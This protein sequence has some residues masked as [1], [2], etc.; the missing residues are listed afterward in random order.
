[1]IPVR[2]GWL[3]ALY[4]EAYFM[5]REGI[6]QKG[7]NPQY[8]HAVDVLASQDPLVAHHELFHINGNALFDFKSPKFGQYLTDCAGMVPGSFDFSL[9]KYRHQLASAPFQ[10]V[11][12]SSLPRF[13]YTEMIMNNPT[14]LCTPTLGIF[15]EKHP[16]VVVVHGKAARAIRLGTTC[17]NLVQEDPEV[18]QNA[19]SDQYHCLLQNMSHVIQSMMQSEESLNHLS[20]HALDQIALGSQIAG[21]NPELLCFKDANCCFGG[22]IAHV[23]ESHMWDKST[24]DWVPAWRGQGRPACTLDSC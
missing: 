24:R 13:Q 17:C 1:M 6:W 21:V 8:A 10:E 15:L 5:S 18:I 9:Y 2:H 14:D 23:H 22:P 11:S 7:S 19:H 3:D 20:L 4:E 16:D 12:M